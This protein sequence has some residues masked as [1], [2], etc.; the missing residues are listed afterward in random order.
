MASTLDIYR[1]LVNE[2]A[3]AFQSALTWHSNGKRGHLHA[4]PGC[5]KLRRHGVVTVNLDLRSALD[6]HTVCGDCLGHGPYPQEQRG[7][8]NLARVLTAIEPQIGQDPGGTL[9]GYPAITAVRRGRLA[10]QLLDTL[11]AEQDLHGMDSWFERV[12]RAVE[13]SIPEAP[14][15]EALDAELLRVVVPR[16][17]Q[18]KFVNGELDPGFWGG[19]ENV[20]RLAGNPEERHYHGNGRNANTP[21]VFFT[22]TWLD[23]L[24]LGHTPEE[25]SR[26][27]LGNGEI[28]PLLGD[29]DK[30][31]LERCM[32]V[33]DRVENENLWEFT[34]RN[35][36]NQ[37]LD[38]LRIAAEAMTVRYASMT[39]PSDN[40]LVG[41]SMNGIRS[42]RRQAVGN[43]VDGV[44]A[45]L[46]HIVGNDERAVVLCHPT[47]AE[48]LAG[49]N[50][51][52]PWTQPVHLDETPSDD[53]LETAVALW[54]P[55]DRY[56]AYEKLPAAI[57][58]ARA[59]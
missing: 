2:N 39:A 11:R 28:V 55:R 27:L 22:K 57:D 18:R 45:A 10:E 37:I 17:L 31:Q 51:Y 50:S 7:A 44:V 6:G 19:R 13:A 56:S 3:P 52:G 8:Y 40:V 16:L 48:Y 53:V 20:S 47:V 58:A 38:A 30:R 12:R 4:S 5:G 43:D 25:A 35:W 33:L 46:Q 24:S 59:L 54:E 42:I 29:P 41:N 15:R 32:I 1:A 34:Q 9:Q 26:L 23:K 49:R 36:Q 21:I 14:T